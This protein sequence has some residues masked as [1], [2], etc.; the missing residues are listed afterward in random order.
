M[1]R[2]VIRISPK[3]LSSELDESEGESLE[4]LQEFCSEMKPSVCSPFSNRVDFVN[5]NE[6][7]SSSHALVYSLAEC[8]KSLLS[9]LIHSSANGVNIYG[10]TNLVL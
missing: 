8:F 3:A 5:D 6:E 10:T 1:V 7:V 4:S 2:I 9:D